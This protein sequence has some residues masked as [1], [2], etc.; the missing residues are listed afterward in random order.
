MLDNTTIN[1]NLSSE[2]LHIA[3]YEGVIVDAICS[4]GFLFEVNDMS[5][6]KRTVALPPLCACGCGERVKRSKIYPYDWNNFIYGHSNRGKYNPNFNSKCI[7]EKAKPAPLCACGC[8]RNVKWSDD[9]KKWN[10]YIHGHHI[11]GKGNPKY[12]LDKYA[13]EKAKIAPLC[14]C[15]CG[16]PVKWSQWDRKW[17]DYIYGHQTRTKKFFISPIGKLPLCECGC[18]EFVKWNFYTKQWNR[19]INGHEKR[20]KN[21]RHKPPDSEAP[22]CKCGC[23]KKVKW[24][25]AKN[26]WRDFIHGHYIRMNHPSKAPEFCKKASKRMSN[27]GA[28]YANSFV[29][30]PSKPQVELFEL[31]KQLYPQAILNYPSLN[32]SIDIAIPDQMIAIE[33]DGSY[34]HQDRETDLQ[35]QQELEAIGWK[36]LRYQDCIPKMDDLKKDLNKQ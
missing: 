32:R 18:K 9:E 28:A 1:S 35:R 36:F 29:Q 3:K 30:N 21:F 22:F 23:K 7:I 31:I 17:N 8:G 13:A 15:G 34:W 24:D 12:G 10:K 16:K 6:F 19:Y 25:K 4:Q 5:R 11:K 20:S 14:A 33:Y 26:D 2:N 27:G